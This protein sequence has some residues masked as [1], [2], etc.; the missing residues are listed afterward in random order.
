MRSLAVASAL[1]ALAALPLSA[2]APTG[3]DVLPE[4]PFLFGT[5]AEQRLVVLA[6]Y[7]DGHVEDVTSKSAFRSASP[8]VAAVGADGVVRAGA[9]GGAVIEARYG[10]L[11]GRTTALVQRTDSPPPVTFGSDVLPVLTKSGCNGGNCHGAMNGQNGF[12]LSL[13]GYHADADYRMIVEGHDGRRID[14]ERPQ[15][16]LL[17]RKPAFEV[18]HGGGQVLV[19]GSPEYRTILAWIQGGARLE[20]T[21]EKRLE[22]LAV[23]PSQIVLRG[24]DASAQLLVTARFSD[25]SETDFTDM[26]HFEAHDQS[27]VDVSA[28]GRVTSLAR[29]QTT[30][31][32]RGLGAVAVARV[33]VATRK[34]PVPDIDSDH[35]IDRLVLA[36]LRDLHVPPSGLAD[37]ATFLRRVY[38]DTIGV[39]PTAGEARAFLADSGPEKRARV[40]DGLLDRP[41]YADFWS[42]YW[43]D[44][45]NNTKQLLYNKGP[46]TFTRWLYDRFRENMPYDEFV[47][48]L[49]TSSGNM[50]DSPATSYFP[51]MKKPLDIA[52]QTSQLFLGVSIEC[53]RCHDHPL[54][55]W[56][57]DDYNGMAAFFSQVRYKGGAGPRNNERILYLDFDREFEHPENGRTYRPKALGAA[58]ARI[59]SWTDRREALADWMTAPD[60]PY[61]ARAIVNRMWKQFMG[62]GIVEPVDDFRDTN[63]PANPSLLDALARD[64]IASGYDLKHLIRTIT[65]SRSYQLSSVPNEANRDDT[66]G[67]SRYYARRL[68]AE[69]L[70]DSISLATGVPEEFPS[71]YP[72]TRAAQLPEPEVPSYFLD[73][74]DRPSRQLVADRVQTNS[75]NQALHLISGETIQDK[76]SD[77]GGTLHRLLE[78]GASDEE[79]VEELYLGALARF[80]D[81]AELAAA[82]RT[83]D[84]AGSRAE[85]LEDLFWALLNSKEFVYQH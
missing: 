17:L 1:V 10:S 8:S 60:N 69:Q 77:R 45:L 74:F 73:V 50:Y 22:S 29:G 51:L 40:V 12:K 66:A 85:G 30:V 37:D 23:H 57:Q 15:N 18:A 34:H 39:I 16:S 54:E 38:L 42:L 70:L 84:A 41:E 36:K 63:P 80:P 79:I 55:K 3:L 75:L 49:L 9:F 43:G 6:R 78:G 68:T 2:S 21:V 65:S 28:G 83:V 61:F 5:G 48:A 56:T 7:A 53:A 76:V 35:F 33:G 71:L 14:L 27:V 32:V 62:R 13:F 4:N 59:D 47:R 19:A 11:T 81:A 46:Y 25:G 31:L 64:F 44:H 58:R 72:G 67:H 20:P 82:R 52:A 26:A 24:A